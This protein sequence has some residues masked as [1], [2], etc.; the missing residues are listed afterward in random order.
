MPPTTPNTH[1]R[2][3]RHETI[4]ALI[5]GHYIRNQAEMRDLLDGEGFEVNQGTLSR[6]LRDLGIR[7]GP[8]GYELPGEGQT[9]PTSAG[10]LARCLREWLLDS[11]PA[12][13]TVVL[14][15][16][17]GC[18]HPIAVA[19]DHAAF[20][21]VLGT[22]AGDDTVLVICPGTREANRLS[23]KLLGLRT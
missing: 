18:A 16:P 14:E 21:D 19:L 10:E 1:G 20:P 3:Q 8:E 23:N 12:Q 7:K 9:V 11:V 5:D 2:T 22:I 6:D 15:T 4:L 13:H 17:P